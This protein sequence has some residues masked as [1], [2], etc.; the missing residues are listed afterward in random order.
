MGRLNGKVAIITGSNSGVGEECAKLFVKEGAKVVICARRVEALNNVKDELIKLNG[1]V[2]ALSV[3]ISKEEDVT[4][5]FLE[6]YKKYGK[7]DILV[8]NAGVLDTNLN[9]I[10]TYLDSD[11]D[12]VIA[13][14]QKGT[15]QVTREALKYFEKTMSGSVVNVASVAGVYGCGGAVYVS[16]KG[17]LV[18]LTKHEALRYAGSEI[19]FNCVCPGSIITPMTTTID[20]KAMNM[21]MMGQ[22]MKHADIAGCKPCQPLD[23]ANVIL[24]LASDESKALTGQVIVSD[25][26]A[27]L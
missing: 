7:I 24:F 26:G 3:D 25:F 9:P 8:N 20:R 22:M 12:R 10:D 15:M 1:D 23:V 13:I 2:L 14:N 21:K 27:D 6:T 16:S 18:G 19:R 11:F 4:K 5:L 17:A